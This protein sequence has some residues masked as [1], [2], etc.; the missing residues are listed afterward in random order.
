MVVE[1]ALELCT[2]LFGVLEI[3]GHPWTQVGPI[4]E[5]PPVDPQPG[6]VHALDQV[7]R[8]IRPG[9]GLHVAYQIHHRSTLCPAIADLAQLPAHH[10]GIEPAM[11]CVPDL[12]SVG[13][14]RQQGVRCQLGFDQVHQGEGQQPEG[15]VLGLHL[16][17]EL[18]IV[19]SGQGATVALEPRVPQDD[20]RRAHL[21]PR[22]GAGHQHH[23]HQDQ[24]GTQSR[25][26]V[27]VGAGGHGQG[28]TLP[29]RR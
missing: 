3:E 8:D 5:G 7:L 23:Q 27:S 22:R 11:M 4:L 26:Q 1:K 9:S 19:V 25:Q 16:L 13:V 12:E 18:Q 17:L 14:A 21:T 6:P 2:V 28:Y 10:L 15:A 20:R 24:E 29:A